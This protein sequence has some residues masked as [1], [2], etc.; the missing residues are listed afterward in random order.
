MLKLWWHKLKHWEYWPSYLVYLPTFFIWVWW[1]IKFKSF[2]FYKFANPKIKNGGL[3]ADSKMSIYHI[4]P[5]SS[6]PKTI[7]VQ[8]EDRQN[9]IE[10]IRDSGLNFPLIVK[11]DVGC[12]GV[13]VEKVSN[14]EE[15]F[16]YASSMSQNFLVQELISF[17]NEI[18]LFY[19]RLPN[20]KKG[21]IS[22]ITLKQFLSI[23]GNG[24]DSIEQLLRKNPRFQFQISKLKQSINLQEILPEN[25]ERCLVPFGNH[26]RGTQFTDGTALITEKLV[27]TFNQILDQI[28]GFYYGRL[29]I[30]YQCFED[31]EIGQHF[32]IIELNGVK[33]E[34]THIYDPKKSFWQAQR[35]I[36]KHQQILKEIVSINLKA[37]R[38]K[39]MG[40]QIINRSR[41]NCFN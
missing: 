29:D 39:Q 40:P 20:Q 7:L 30:R 13:G 37:K 38:E 19:Y 23:T 22:G 35:E 17:P 3:Y 15:L 4:L 9:I 18:G 10:K 2:K 16:S 24:K 6:F 33:S 21:K 34:P 41:T 25:E 1:M 12:R 5:P 31:L 8:K 11:P 26:S 27:Q 36:L 28:D 32:S 14:F